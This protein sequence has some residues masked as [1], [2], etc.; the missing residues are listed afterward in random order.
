LFFFTEAASLMVAFPSLVLFFVSLRGISTSTK[1]PQA[2]PVSNWLTSITTLLAEPLTPLILP[3]AL[4]L[5]SAL[6]GVQPS[7]PLWL[8][9]TP[10]AMV[11]EPL[12]VVTPSR[13]QLGS[14]SVQ[15]TTLFLPSRMTWLGS[16]L[17]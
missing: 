12:G 15:T 5:S 11:H 8:M 2:E 1:A 4:A 14:Q 7:T 6:G 16:T 10:V 17:L 3:L 13:S 9:Q